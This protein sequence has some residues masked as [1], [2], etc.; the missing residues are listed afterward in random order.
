MSE[1]RHRL[2]SIPQ[3][4]IALDSMYETILALKQAVEQLLG[5]RNSN[6]PGTPISIADISDA[7]DQRIKTERNS[8]IGAYI[9]GGAITKAKIAPDL[10][11]VEVVVALPSTG[12]TVGRIAFLTTDNRVYVWNGTAWVWVGT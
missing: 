3:P 10:N 2:P 8:V 4:T 11:F 9:E 6:L 12:N 1:H 7:L 5:Q